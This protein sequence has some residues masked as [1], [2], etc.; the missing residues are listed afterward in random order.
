LEHRGSWLGS[1]PLG[2][3]LHWPGHLLGLGGEP[4]GL[5]DWCRSE[6]LGLLNWCRSKSLGLLDWLR[7]KPLG[8]L[9]GLG[10]KSLLLLLGSE[11]LLCLELLKLLCCC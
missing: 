10:N 1:K 9:L 3:L 11:C 7:S 4:L 6:P 5:W 2:L 8:L